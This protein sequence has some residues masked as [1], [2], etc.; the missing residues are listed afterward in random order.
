MFPKQ[1]DKRLI[2][3]Y[4]SNYLSKQILMISFNCENGGNICDLSITSRLLILIN[5][6]E[7]YF[8]TELIL[9]IKTWSF[10]IFGEITSAKKK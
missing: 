4:A 10:E 8:S 5:F 9:I 3:V 7:T 1:M 6:L 2:P